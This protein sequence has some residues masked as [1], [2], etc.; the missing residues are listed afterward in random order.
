M[1]RSLSGCLAVGTVIA[2]LGVACSTSG[3]ADIAYGQ[4]ECDYCKMT[5]A[6]KRFGS[7]FI[8]NKGKV[9]K[10]D[11]IEC[12]AAFQITGGAALPSPKTMWVTDFSHP[13]TF[14][15]IDQAA[16][17]A[18]ARQKSP[19]GVGLLAVGS[20]REAKRLIEAV[21][22]DLVSWQQTQALVTKEWKL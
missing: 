20:E 13:G 2:A 19:M 18:S 15:S 14:L 10:F 5:I 17:I 1:R 3:P 16:L 8:S 12:L 21:G 9:Y 7:E 4:D 11:S 22:G 6:D